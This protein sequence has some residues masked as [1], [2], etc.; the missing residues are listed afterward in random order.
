M[1]RPVAE[2]RLKELLVSQYGR[3][4]GPAA[5]EFVRI[6]DAVDASHHDRI[7]DGV[8]AALTK[9]NSY[10]VTMDPALKRLNIDFKWSRELMISYAAEK[11]GLEMGGSEAVRLA[12]EYFIAVGRSSP[13]YPDVQPYLNALKRIEIFVVTGSDS[14]LT[15]V[16]GSF[17]YDPSYSSA[18]KIMRLRYAGLKADVNDA[19]I[20]CSDPYNKDGDE[21]WQEVYRR[22]GLSDFS[23]GTF[24]DDS[25][26]IVRMA[27]KAGFRGYLLD[28]DGRYDEKEV[29]HEVDGYLTRL[30]QLA[31]PR[32]TPSRRA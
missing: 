24:V 15:Y 12:D 13:L 11:T 5:D 14:R 23:Q 30:D 31:V 9:L 20:I 22:T 17:H 7:D 32:K 19:H 28:R 10:D 18:K 1:N 16:D 21:F 8:K 27:K 2:R 6:Y 26:A 25:L 4:G 29:G 3:A